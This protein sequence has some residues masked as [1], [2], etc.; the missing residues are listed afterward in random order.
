MRTVRRQAQ[1]DELGEHTEE[2]LIDVLEMSWDDIT[3]LHEQGIILLPSSR[4]GHSC[5]VPS[6]PP[7]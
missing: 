2:I 4:P 6:V 7:Q 3:K 1:T 5:E